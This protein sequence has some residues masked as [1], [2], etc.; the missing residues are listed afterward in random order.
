MRHTLIRATLASPRFRDERTLL[1]LAV[2]L[3][4]GLASPRAGQA[5][6]TAARTLSRSLLARPVSGQTSAARALQPRDHRVAEIGATRAPQQHATATQL[7]AARSFSTAEL[8]TLLHAR[9]ATSVHVLRQNGAVEHVPA[10]QGG[11]TLGPKDFAFWK[12]SN[13]ATVLSRAA[14]DTSARIRWLAASPG[15]RN[16]TVA[17][18]PYRCLIEDAAGRWSVLA[19]VVVFEGGLAYDVATHQ[20]RG[21]AY[22]GAEDTLSPGVARRALARPIRMLLTMSAPGGGVAPAQTLVDHLGLDY[23]PL[24]ITATGD[25]VAL[26]VRAWGDSDGVVVPLRDVIVPTSRPRVAISVLPPV[27][28]G[29]GLGTARITVALMPG[30]ATRPADTVTVHFS[31]DVAITPAAV[32]ATV[33]GVN[34]A[35]IRSG[36][37]GA[38]T[39]TASV[40]GLEAG[41]TTL[42]FVTPFSFFA[43]ALVGI[44]LGVILKWSTGTQ[45]AVRTLLVASLVAGLILAIVAA[46]MSVQVGSVKLDSTAGFFAVAIAGFVGAFGGPA[47]IEKLVKSG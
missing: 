47:G 35:T 32:L 33:N 46:Y 18:L 9:S 45:L 21:T 38:H 29:Y 6:S 25:S 2:G 41:T 15:V 3:L 8:Q 37:P 11:V 14:A 24:A 7:P 28:Q 1:L 5:Q 31:S 12:E 10:G 36:S 30:T 19:P 42:Q 22:L 43:W 13:R 44:V 40:D 20:F 16:R 34:E 23:T 4:L 27:V 26:R 39:I 17:V